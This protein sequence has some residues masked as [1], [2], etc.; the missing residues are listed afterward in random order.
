LLNGGE[1]LI[2]QAGKPNMVI[3]KRYGHVCTNKAVGDCAK[4]FVHAEGRMRNG[5]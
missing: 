3:A 1:H 5:G 4:R 2:R